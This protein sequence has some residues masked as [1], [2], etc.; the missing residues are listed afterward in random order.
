MLEKTDGAIKNGQSRETGLR[1]TMKNKTKTQHNRYWTPLFVNIIRSKSHFKDIIVLNSLT[2]SLKY[3]CALSQVANARL[4]VL[5]KKKMFHIINILK[6]N[7]YH[8]LKLYLY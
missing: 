2:L 1:K 3:Q 4:S 8:I 5:Q 6:H 7:L